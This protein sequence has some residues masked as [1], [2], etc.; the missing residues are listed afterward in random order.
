MNEYFKRNFNRDNQNFTGFTLV[1]LLIVITILTIIASMLLS[2]LKEAI[3]HTR[4]IECTSRLR[5]LGLALTLYSRDF[6]GYLPHEDAG[7][8]TSA[9]RECCWFDVIDPYLEEQNLSLIKQCPMDQRFQKDH[10]IKMNS[11]LESGTQPFFRLGQAKKESLVPLLF[12]GRVDTFG[13]RYQTK[14]YWSSAACRHRAGTNLLFL[15]FH[16]S[17]YGPVPGLTIYGGWPDQ[18]PFFW[19]QD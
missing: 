17:W 15:D 14:G 9:P 5:Q 3:I 4:S 19:I 2:V 10:S 18:G 11:R 6:D 1:E 13:Y 12:D 16:S 7:G 8:V